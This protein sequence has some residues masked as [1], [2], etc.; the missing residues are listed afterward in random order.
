M[1][2]TVLTH[3]TRG[4]VQPYI[5]LAQG[6]ESAGHHLRIAADISFKDFV[7]DQGLEYFPAGDYVASLTKEMGRWLEGKIELFRGL[8]Y[9]RWLT[10]MLPSLLN[11]W[12]KA[13]QQ[14]DA[15]IYTP[16]VFP[17]YHIAEKLGVPGFS[18]L[19]NPPL[20]PTRAFPSCYIPFTLPLGG[21]FNWFTH[22]FSSLLIWLPFKR[23]INRWRKESLGLP[24]LP[25]SGRPYGRDRAAKT[26]FLYGFS[27]LIIPPP[28]DWHDNVH[29]TGYWFLRH[30]TSWR[31]SKEL[32]EFLESGPPP[33]YIGFGSAV[34]ERSAALTRLT[35]DAL[36]RAGQRGI[37]MPLRGGLSSLRLP[38][39]VFSFDFIP[40]DW[41]FPQMAAIVHHGGAG[42]TAETLHSGV[43]S[44]VV[45]FWIEEEYWGRK[46]ANL[47]VGSQPISYRRLTSEKLAKAIAT[48]TENQ[49]M[50]QR[51]TELAQKIRSEDGIRQAV[52]V[53]NKYL[54][55]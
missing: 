42:T 44:I 19:V 6:L 24:P 25:I 29:V 8:Y 4:D 40:H 54:L 5:A 52:A 53:I 9:V 31:P 10:P 34:P 7:Q 47:G 20:T 2:I 55:K 37:I 27:P 16:T 32:L 28:P 22:V 46:V 26:P 51:A 12:W 11:D 30:S 45:S 39:N 18:A 23:V 36:E 15:I 49:S 1:D 35:L 21:T 48:V 13:C 33:V 3:G 50:R 43:P 38:P 17:G 14:T 41:L